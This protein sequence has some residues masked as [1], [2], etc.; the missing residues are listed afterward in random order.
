[1]ASTEKVIKDDDG[2]EH[3]ILPNQIFVFYFGHLYGI[4]AD[5]GKTLNLAEDNED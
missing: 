1:L 3:T 2:K 4:V 5:D